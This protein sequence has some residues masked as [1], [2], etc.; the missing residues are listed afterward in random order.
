MECC[1][2]WKAV[3]YCI[4]PLRG[5]KSHFN[6]RSNNN[7]LTTVHRSVQST[8]SSSETYT[9]LCLCYSTTAAS[10]N[11]LTA[12]IVVQTLTIV[13]IYICWYWN[14]NVFMLIDNKE[15][16]PGH[17]CNY[18]EMCTHTAADKW[19]SPAAISVVL[20]LR[21]CRI[22]CCLGSV[23]FRLYGE[24]A[25]QKLYI[26]PRYQLRTSV[27]CLWTVWSAMDSLLHWIMIIFTITN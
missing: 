6:I 25:E 24:R 7:Q 13:Y 14:V 26:L 17:Y 9:T 12:E 19:K 21:N 8:P 23:S 27:E 3:P 5:S 2:V 10:L 20:Q 11:K 15:M 4:G 1:K 18:T 22:L 16:Y